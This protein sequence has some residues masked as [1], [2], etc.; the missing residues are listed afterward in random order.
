MFLCRLISAAFSAITGRG[1][2]A[3]TEARE[4]Q[5]Q[6]DDEWWANAKPFVPNLTGAIATD[7]YD[8]DTLTIAVRVDGKPHTF[9]VRIYGIDCP[10]LKTQNATEHRWAQI[11][12][13][14]VEKR[15]LLNP[16]ARFV[17]RKQ[18]KYGRLL[19][20]VFVPQT[21]PKIPPPA[22]TVAAQFRTIQDRKRVYRKGDNQAA[23]DLKLMAELE[24]IDSQ[25]AQRGETLLAH[26]LLD[27]R[28]ALPYAGKTKQPP[29]CWEA[30]V[31]FGALE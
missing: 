13:E 21:S 5:Q 10:E 24:A 12:K 8:G 1:S 26:R 2:A 16:K 15:V 30:Y 14:Y 23:A 9:K 4:L 28:Y 31:V 11:A 7:V 22:L 6:S 20:D 19:C 29:K 3:P 18:D 27:N 25:A 17:Y